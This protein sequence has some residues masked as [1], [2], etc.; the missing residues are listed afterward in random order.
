MSY[1]PALGMGHGALG[2][3][4]G[5]LGGAKR[6]D[7]AWG[8]G[9]SE[10]EG[11]GMGHRALGIGHRASGIGRSEA[12]GWG[13]GHGAI[14]TTLESRYSGPETVIGSAPLVENF[15]FF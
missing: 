10:A 15:Y 8:I 3:G 1:Y 4:H 2:M 7:G 11:W 14:L 12:E 5:A 9:R 6:R 13:M